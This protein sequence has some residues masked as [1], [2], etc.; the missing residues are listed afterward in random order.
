[1]KLAI[2][3]AKTDPFYEFVESANTPFGRPLT[4]LGN[5][6]SSNKFLLSMTET[7]RLLYLLL[8]FSLVLALTLAKFI[9]IFVAERRQI[10]GGNN[11]LEG[12]FLLSLLYCMRFSS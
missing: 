2:I 1:M 11:M 12:T 5:V 8:L 6:F 3:V 4:C 7:L 9:H 10:K